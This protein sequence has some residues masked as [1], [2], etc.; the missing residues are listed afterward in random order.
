MSIQAFDLL[1]VGEFGEQD[2]AP[3]G[4]EGG[5]VVDAVSFLGADLG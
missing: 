3:A 4:R 2:D 1:E 5:V